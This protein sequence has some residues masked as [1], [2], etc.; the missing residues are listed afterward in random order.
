VR[1]LLD[2]LAAVVIALVFLGGSAIDSVTHIRH[3]VNQKVYPWNW[4]IVSWEVEAVT[5]KVS[6]AI[7]RPTAGMTVEEQTAHVL[8]YLERAREI[9]DLERDM[10]RIY[11][12]TGGEATAES[13]AIQLQIDALRA[14]QE[15]ARPAAEVILEA[16]IT[17]ELSDDGIGWS[18]APLRSRPR[19][20]S[21]AHAGASPT[22]TMR[23]FSPPCRSRN[24]SALKTQSSHRTI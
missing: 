13:T 20:S 16:Q 15:R 5:E 19:S 21:S 1:R 4:D 7:R 11:S 23:C 22:L 18:G 6:A 2:R 12:D 9:R 10:E 24:A 3:S 8:S 17:A 14:E